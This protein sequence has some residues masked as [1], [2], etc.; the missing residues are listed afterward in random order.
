MN[1]ILKTIQA[2]II[3]QRESFFL[4]NV[5]FGRVLAWMR[6]FPLTRQNVCFL[7]VFHLLYWLRLNILRQTEILIREQETLH[8]IVIII[9]MKNKW[10][11]S[12]LSLLSYQWYVLQGHLSDNRQSIS[13]L[14][15]MNADTLL[16][17]SHTV[18][19][20]LNSLYSNPHCSLL[21]CITIQSGTFHPLS[22]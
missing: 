3:M 1:E 20:I 9:H 21:I 19:I 5:C 4:P 18:K 6:S 10:N 8:R 14:D 12:W 15:K 13:W 16:T 2:W 7:T 22:T 11:M 17:T